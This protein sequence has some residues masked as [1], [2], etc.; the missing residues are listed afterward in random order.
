MPVRHALMGLLAQQPRHGY[1]LHAAFDALLVGRSDWSVKPAQVYTTLTRMEES[2]LVAQTS[3]RRVGGPDQHIY[4]LTPAGRRELD[5]WYAIG[6]NPIYHRDEFYIK[7]ILAISDDGVDA[8]SLVRA[9]RATLYRVLHELTSARSDLDRTDALA[10]AMLLDKAV[11][12]VE[13]DLRWLEMVEARLHQLE[14]QALPQ[15]ARRRRG[16]PRKSD[17]THE[18]GR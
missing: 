9:Q 11:M 8:E 10:H 13:A 5:R 12:H 15:P 16:R 3:I 14:R 6:V 4:E 7:L 18:D 1:E 17:S 2:G